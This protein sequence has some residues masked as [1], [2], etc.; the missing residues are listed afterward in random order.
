MASTHAL[1]VVCENRGAMR[2]WQKGVHD[3]AGLVQRDRVRSELSGDD[4][5]STQRLGLKHLDDSRIADC[6]IR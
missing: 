5:Q 3:V 1:P 2:L 6:Y 4:L